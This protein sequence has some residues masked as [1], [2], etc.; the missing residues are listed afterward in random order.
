[1][2]KVNVYLPDRLAEAVRAY[3]IPISSVC[4]RA[5]EQEVA[6]RSS[7]LGLTPRSR[8]VL[9]T[10]AQ[11]AEKL[12]DNFVGTEHLLL[13]LI[14]EGEGIAAQALDAVGATQAVRAKLEAMIQSSRSEG[15]SNRAVDRQGNLIGYMLQDEEGNPFVIGRDGQA[16]HIRHDAEGN[17]G[18]VDDAGTPVRLEPAKSA[19]RLVTTDG[20]GGVVVLVDAEGRRP[21][22]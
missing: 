13:G 19:P 16:I 9:A 15:P 12:G 11:E 5:L 17:L 2:P 22:D 7:V 18:V 14:A 21:G 1:M 10:A 20:A 3:Q 4:Q 8:A 6:A